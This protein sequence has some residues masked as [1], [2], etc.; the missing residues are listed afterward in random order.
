M[1]SSNKTRL[2]CGAILRFSVISAVAD[3]IF[4]AFSLPHVIF[5]KLIGIVMF[6]GNQEVKESTQ[7]DNN[8]QQPPYT[9]TVKSVCS[10]LDWG[11]MRVLFIYSQTQ[12]CTVS[13]SE[14]IYSLFWKEYFCKKKNT[15]FLENKESFQ[16]CS[17]TVC[18]K[19]CTYVWCVIRK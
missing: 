2:F 8:T 17:M 18:T 12:T 14:N 1:V 13:W 3:P 15:F 4:F 5:I 11:Y 7:T 19:L 16:I 9:T 10:L 6:V